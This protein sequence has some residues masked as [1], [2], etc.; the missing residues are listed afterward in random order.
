MSNES[1]II[2]GGKAQLGRWTRATVDG[3]VGILLGSTA[4]AATAYAIDHH[5][6][7]SEQAV[8]DEAQAT[9]GNAPVIL[10]EARLAGGVSDNMSFSQAFATA[11]AEVGPGG[12]FTWHGGVYGTY[13]EDEW[14]AMDDADRARY[15]A[16]ISPDISEDAARSYSHPAV[17]HDDVAH[18]PAQ[19]QEDVAHGGHDDS[20]VHEASE[21]GDVKVLGTQELEDGTQLTAIEVDGHGGMVIG[22]N[23]EADIAIIDIDDSGDLTPPDVIIDMH[24]GEAVTAEEFAMQAA[25]EIEAGSNVMVTQ[26]ED[27]AAEPVECEYTL[28]EED[29][30]ANESLMGDDFGMA[31]DIDVVSI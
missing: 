26:S 13:Y 4:G 1:T 12:V 11:R 5:N 15:Y 17:Q 21:Q 6:N 3:S 19:P 14:N 28:P 7:E 18:A 24:T 29:P 8:A 25:K 30:A 27:T 22:S 2:S 20:H 9:D 10:D 31:S 16:S 23:G